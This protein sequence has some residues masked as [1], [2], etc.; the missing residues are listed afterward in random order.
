MLGVFWQAGIVRRAGG[1]TLIELL[2][3]ISIIA[4][5]M[6]LLLP[7][8]KLVEVQAKDIVCRSRLRQWGTYFHLYTE[9]YDGFFPEGWPHAE[10]DTGSQLG[11]RMWPVTIAPYFDIGYDLWCCP[12]ADSYEPV[13]DRQEPQMVGTFGTWGPKPASWPPSDDD[14]GLYLL[15]VG[16]YGS[17]GMNEWAYSTLEGR[18]KSNGGD[19]HWGVINV[20]GGWRVPLFFDCS[21]FDAQPFTWDDPPDYSGAP[22]TYRY[23]DEMSRVCIDRHRGA[24]NVLYFDRSVRRAALKALWSLKWHRGFEVQGPFTAAGGMIESEWPAWLANY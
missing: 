1:F 13:P 14:G 20:E 3:V 15:N 5:L 23:D 7:A 24:V 17:Y 4:L 12:V 19:D 18:L 22:R 6:S 16:D 11:N 2:V 10:E 9:D 8:L 21:W